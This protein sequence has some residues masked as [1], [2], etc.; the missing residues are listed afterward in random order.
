MRPAH[1]FVLDLDPS[2]RNARLSQKGAVLDRLEL[3]GDEFFQR[4]RG[5]FL[6]MAKANPGI[7]TVLDAS[8]PLNQLHEVILKKVRELL[9]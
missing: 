1:I 9:G 8:L 2:K 6:S 4:V 7:S 5:G 3:E